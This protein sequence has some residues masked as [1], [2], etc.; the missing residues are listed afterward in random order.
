MYCINESCSVRANLRT[1]SLMV[2]VVMV[3][4]IF[5]EQTYMISAI[6]TNEMKSQW[7]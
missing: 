1:S 5:I 7:C 2:V 6:H 3:A 4:R